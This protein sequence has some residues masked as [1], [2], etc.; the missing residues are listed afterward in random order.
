[1]GD[2]NTKI[3]NLVDKG[4]RPEIQ[5]SLDVVR[6][7]G[8]ESVHPEELDIR[9]DPETANTLFELVN[10]VVQT[11]ITDPKRAKE[12]YDKFLNLKKIV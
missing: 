9:D 1:M 5:Q 8:N 6:V 11:M 10:L 4:L 2:L 3:G 7:I 12:I